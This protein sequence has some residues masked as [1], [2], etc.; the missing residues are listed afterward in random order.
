MA[1]KRMLQKMVSLKNIK[2]DYDIYDIQLHQ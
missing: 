1:N 2:I